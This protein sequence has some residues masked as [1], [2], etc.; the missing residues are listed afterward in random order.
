MFFTL[1]EKDECRTVGITHA[2]TKEERSWTDYY[3]SSKYPLTRLRYSGKYIITEK[4]EMLKST[5]SITSN[6][7]TYNN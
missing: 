4:T 1:S 3:F 7:R 5:S 6:R 2:V